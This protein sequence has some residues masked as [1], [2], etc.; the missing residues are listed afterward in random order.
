MLSGLQVLA[1]GSPRLTRAKHACPMRAGGALLLLTLLSL[2]SHGSYVL[3]C[4]FVS[5][6]VLH[7]SALCFVFCKCMVLASAGSTR[8]KH[9]CPM[10]MAAH[11]QFVCCLNFLKAIYSTSDWVPLSL[12]LGFVVPCGLTLWLV[13]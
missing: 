11:A 10:S 12:V 3:H 7:L 5:R 2:L 13:A 1:S 4:F 8:A 9:D 6:I